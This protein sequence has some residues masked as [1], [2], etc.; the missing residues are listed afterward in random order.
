MEQSF[1][2]AFASLALCHVGGPFLNLRYGVCHRNRGSGS[3]KKRQIIGVVTE[4]Y[5]LIN[6]LLPDRDTP[7]PG[8][9][10]D[11]PSHYVPKYGQ[12]TEN[13][14][15]DLI[16]LFDYDTPLF[17]FLLGTGEEDAPLYPYIFAGIGVVA[18]IVLI[19]FGRK[20]KHKEV[21]D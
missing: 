12:R 1:R 8:E 3:L 19:V 7:E 16:D 13:E 11:T 2:E 6:T 15:L 5:D 4:G 9:E 20:R 14:L 21:R 18:V 10:E 17:G